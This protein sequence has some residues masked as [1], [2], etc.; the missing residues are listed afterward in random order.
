VSAILDDV[1]VAS[2]YVLACLARPIS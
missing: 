1:D 2:V